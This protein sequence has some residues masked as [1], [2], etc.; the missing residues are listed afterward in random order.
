[1]ASRKQVE[2]NRR[3]GR[4]GG[5]RTPEG[6]AVSRLNARKHGIF[7]SALTPMD[8]EELHG[9]HDRCRAELQPVGFL[10]E[11]IVDKIAAVYLSLQR[12]ALA[13][14]EYHLLTWKQHPCQA[15]WPRRHP[16]DRFDLNYFETTVV[17]VQRYD[18]TLTN[19]FL[20]LIHELQ[21]LQQRP[22]RGEEA[23]V[24]ADPA[25]LRN[26]PNTSQ[27]LCTQE[28]AARPQSLLSPRESLSDIGPCPVPGQPAARA[29]GALDSATT[30]HPAAPQAALR[31][32]P[33]PTPRPA[34][35]PVHDGSCP[36][37]EASSRERPSSRPTD[38]EPATTQ[39]PSAPGASPRNE[40]NPPQTGPAQYDAEDALDAIGL[41]SRRPAGDVPAWRDPFQ[42]HPRLPY[43]HR[44]GPASDAHSAPT[45]R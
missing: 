30:D 33:N 41:T 14:A 8:H 25:R 21:A 36:A 23:L 43:W 44:R 1:M 7:A 40:P 38:L 15:D 19:Q 29:T 27:Q 26:E 2:A 42:P 39:D 24:P 28:G 35:L 12:C 16:D 22:S 18:T 32:E 10:E 9:T 45:G 20:K 34:P 31:N 13:H 11:A 3:N 4:L 17:L 5:P 6:K 37:G